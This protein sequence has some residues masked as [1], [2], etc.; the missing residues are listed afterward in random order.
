MSSVC[1]AD[2]YYGSL[3]S[4]LINNG[5][6]PAIVEP[7]DSR[8]I[9]SITTDN[10]E[11]QIYTK[12]VSNSTKRRNNHARLWQFV[13]SNDEIEVIKNYKDNG[14]KFIF[15]LICGQEKF[16][17]SEISI[18]SLDEMKDCLGIEYDYETYRITVKAEKGVHG[19][20]IYGSGRADIL[21]EKDNTIRVPRDLI[22]CF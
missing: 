4:V 19:L 8:R 6:A 11:Y 16:Q 1:K 10:G 9:Y 17:D 15:A 21:N 7:G 20:K 13:F 12:Y 14:K 18:L 2:F 5:I 3:L 22:A